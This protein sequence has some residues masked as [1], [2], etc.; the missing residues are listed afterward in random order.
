MTFYLDFDGTVVE[1]AYPKIGREN[2][3]AFNVIKKL[4]EAGH[5]IILNTYRVEANNNTLNEALEYLN[6]HPYY[7]IETISEHCPEKREP[8]IWDWITMKETKIIYIDDITKN[9]PLRKCV[10]SNNYM[11][12]WAEVNKQ[13]IENKIY[14]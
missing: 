7:P 14:E 2:P 13:F 6:L 11:V 8:A 5:K 3:G 12:D 9:I 1:H 10:T 4:Q